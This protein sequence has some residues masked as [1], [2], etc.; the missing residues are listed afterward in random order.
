MT[1]TSSEVEGMVKSLSVVFTMHLLNRP[2]RNAIR[3]RIV[4]AVADL[5]V[6]KEKQIAA[7]QRMASLFLAAFSS[8]R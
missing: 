6:A 3:S 5:F 1:G 4:P 2:G 8:E 7:S